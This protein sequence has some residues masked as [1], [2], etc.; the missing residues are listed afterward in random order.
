MRGERVF[1]V[2][3]LVQFRNGDGLLIDGVVVKE[4]PPATLI[5]RYSDECSK[6]AWSAPSFIVKTDAGIEHTVARDW[7]EVRDTPMEREFRNLNNE[8]GRHIQTLLQEADDKI[9]EA[10]KLSETHGLPF[11]SPVCDLGQSFCPGSFKTLYPNLDEDVA[12]V[13][14]DSDHIATYSG[15]KH[16]AIGC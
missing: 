8:V 6:I 14:S 3:D 16:F 12:K 11:Y 2:G 10:K 13:I 5:D 1:A 9:Y 15:W 4:I 7:L